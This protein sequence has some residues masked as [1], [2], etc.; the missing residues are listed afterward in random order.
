M[1][2]GVWLGIDI[3]GSKVQGVAIDAEGGV[4]AQVRLGSTNGADGVAATAGLALRRLRALPAVGGRPLVAVGVGVP[5]VVDVTAG[6]VRHAV[7]LGL[8]AA[9]LALSD[10]LSTE[11]GCPVVVENDVNAAALGAWHLRQPVASDLAYLSIGTGLAAG[12][13]LGWTAPARRARGRGR[14]RPHPG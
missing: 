3:G 6:H 9:G 12:I 14:D 13:V 4:L 10:A 8:G 1:T 5:G 2:D 7:N 11:A